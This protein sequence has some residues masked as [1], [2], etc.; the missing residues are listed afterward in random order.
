MGLSGA[1]REE[2]EARAPQP[3][4]ALMTVLFPKDQQLGLLGLLVT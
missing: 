1:A 2:P 4:G 3:R